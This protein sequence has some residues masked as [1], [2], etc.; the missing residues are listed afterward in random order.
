MAVPKRKKS[1]A[2]RDS[3]RANHDRITLPNVSICDNCG[4]DVVSHRACGECGW[5]R[6]RVAVPVVEHF[7]EIDDLAEAS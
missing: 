5:Y 1:K 6:D 7:E 4:A 3:R 2:R